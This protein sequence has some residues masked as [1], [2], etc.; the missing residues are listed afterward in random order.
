MHAGIGQYMRRT[1]LIAKSDKRQTEEVDAQGFI[2][3]DFVA[4]GNRVPEVDIHQDVLRKS[5]VNGVGNNF[6]TTGRKNI[7]QPDF[8]TRLLPRYPFSGED[9]EFGVS[10]IP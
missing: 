10:A 7:I 5:G 8:F 4:A 9:N 1:V 2:V 6:T 3:D